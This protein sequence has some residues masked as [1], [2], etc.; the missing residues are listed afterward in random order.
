MIYIFRN[1]A[2]FEQYMKLGT[3]MQMATLVAYR[4]D[5][6]DIFHVIKNRWNGMT[7]AN[8]DWLLTLVGRCLEPKQIAIEEL[9]QNPATA[10]RQIVESNF[11][12]SM[13]DPQFY[14]SIKG[15]EQYCQQP[16]PDDA[17]DN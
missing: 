10:L 8:D 15:W 9:S 7:T 16:V 6:D 5:K 17:G 4:D 1:R 12:R 2:E 11:P 13:I 3:Q 14:E